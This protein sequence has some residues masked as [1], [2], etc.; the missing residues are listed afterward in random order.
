MPEQGH[1][2]ADSALVLTYYDIF[3]GYGS[4]K[5][6]LDIALHGKWFRKCPIGVQAPGS[7]FVSPPGQTQDGRPTDTHNAIW[8]RQQQFLDYILSANLCGVLCHA[9]ELACQCVISIE[10]SG[11]Q[12][13]FSHKNTIFFRAYE[14]RRCIVIIFQP[15][16]NAWVEMYNYVFVIG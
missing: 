10:T 11:H 4:C 16:L 12:I 7:I 15:I 6:A 8:G 2:R 1:N 3:I 5:N 9:F 13:F 14:L